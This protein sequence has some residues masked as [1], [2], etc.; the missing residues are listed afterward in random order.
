MKNV[1]FSNISWEKVKYIG[2]DMDG[3]LYDEYEFVIQ[4]YKKISKLFFNDKQVFFFLSNRWLE[5]GS[6]YNKIF[7]EAY[8]N[9][10]EKLKD[11]ISEEDFINQ[12]LDIY[13]NFEEKDSCDFEKAKD[14]FEKAHLYQKELFSKLIT[15]EYL[16]KNNINVENE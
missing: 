1:L 9:F 11:S 6:S 8:K 15:K 4:P 16:Q 14:V 13:R 7:G 10:N 5:K 2:F 12:C 3:T